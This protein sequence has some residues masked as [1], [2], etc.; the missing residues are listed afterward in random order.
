MA[1]W[2]DDGLDLGPQF[3]PRW[4]FLCSEHCIAECGGPVNAHHFLT[5]HY[6]G[7]LQSPFG[8]KAGVN[9]LSI[10]VI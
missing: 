8:A 4:V 6:K 10:N 5:L 2:A 9:E 7:K 3:S 1:G